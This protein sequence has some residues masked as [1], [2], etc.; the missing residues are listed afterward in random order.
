MLNVIIGKK[1]IA[2]AQRLVYGSYP[3]VVN[4]VGEE[5]L[6]LNEL[7]YTKVLAGALCAFTL[8]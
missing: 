1:M 8:P 7:A 3:E 5:M 4:H 2:E 6:I